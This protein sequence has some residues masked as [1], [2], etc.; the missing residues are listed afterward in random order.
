MLK[1]LWKILDSY[2]RTLQELFFPV[3]KTPYDSNIESVILD[4]HLLGSKLESHKSDIQA[5]QSDWEAIGKDFE[6]VFSYKNE[7]DILIGMIIE[8]EDGKYLCEIDTGCDINL[9]DFPEE[10][11]PEHAKVT[12]QFML[13]CGCRKLQLL[14]TKPYEEDVKGKELDKMIAS[15]T[16]EK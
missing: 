5:L 11:F 15:L 4:C 2:F 7:G 1:Y 13:C 3:I 14:P 16:E 9:F 10:W 6:T 12:D 8:K